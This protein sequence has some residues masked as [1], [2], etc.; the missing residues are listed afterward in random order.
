MDEPLYDISAVCKM[1]GATSR[2]LRYYE[3][4]GLIGSTVIPPS[5]RRSYTQAQL[6]QVREV[7]LLRKL[8]LSTADIAALQKENTDLR[9]AMELRIA[10]LY[11]KITQLQNELGLLGEALSVMDSGGDVYDTAHYMPEAQKDA[12]RIR[13]AE[14]CARAIAKGDAATLYSHL[15][16]QIKARM[17][18]NIFRVVREDVLRPLGSF[19]AYECTFRDPLVE[20]KVLSFVKYENLG[21]KIS[22]VFRGEEICGLWMTYYETNGGGLL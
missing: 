20:H 8:G 19:V 5:R 9:S 10:H 12:L 1:L 14:S 11:A 16:E 7:L 22:F 21:L 3:E 2:T 13:I 17:P 4:K 18:E 15:G 6:R